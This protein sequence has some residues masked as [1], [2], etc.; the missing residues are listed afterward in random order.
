[1]FKNLFNNIKNLFKKQEFFSCL[2]FDGKS[3]KYLD[4]TQK[5]IDALSK[6]NKHWTITKKEDC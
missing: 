3:M 4:L 2:I 5:Q 6:K 1:M